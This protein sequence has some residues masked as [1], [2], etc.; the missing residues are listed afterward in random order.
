MEVESC[1]WKW[2]IKNNFLFA[3][4]LSNQVFIV[5]SQSEA[6]F[7]FRPCRHP[8]WF[9]KRCCNHQHTDRSQVLLWL[10]EVAMLSNSQSFDEDPGDGCRKM[11]ATF[12]VS[13]HHLRHPPVLQNS[14]ILLCQVLWDG[15]GSVRCHVPGKR[16][17]LEQ[18]HVLGR[19]IHQDTPEH[20]AQ[21]GDQGFTHRRRS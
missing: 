5:E 19:G 4:K 3:V 15:S 16:V 20:R 21:V 9:C 7:F 13:A 11:G 2:R 8:I 10:R 18:P 14:P 6:L 12:L 17:L 1:A